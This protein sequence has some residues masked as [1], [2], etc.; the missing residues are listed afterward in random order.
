MCT[1]INNLTPPLTPS[2][3][4]DSQNKVIKTIESPQPMDINNNDKSN[5]PISTTLTN[6][7]DTHLL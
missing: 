5:K 7:P 2:P 4:H 6:I 3:Y 1:N